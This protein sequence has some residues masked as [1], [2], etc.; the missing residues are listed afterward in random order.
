MKSFF[1]ESIKPPE[2]PC[3]MKS[4]DGPDVILLV[5]NSNKACVEGMVIYS[6]DSCSPLGEYS[7]TWDKPS[8]EIIHGNVTING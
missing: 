3:L 7:K 5:T 6:E 2:Y 1:K 8:F 4:L